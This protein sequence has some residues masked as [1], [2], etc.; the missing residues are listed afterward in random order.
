MHLELLMIAVVELQLFRLFILMRYLWYWVCNYVL[1]A[2]FVYV[3]ELHSRKE[4]LK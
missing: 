2:F 1:F 3:W 4:S